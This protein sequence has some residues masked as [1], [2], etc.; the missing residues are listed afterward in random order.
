MLYFHHFCTKVLL[1]CRTD[2]FSI[3][4]TNVHFPIYRQSNTC[5][6][7]VRSSAGVYFFLILLY[8]HFS[9]CDVISTSFRM[10]HTRAA[11]ATLLCLCFEAL[12]GSLD[13]KGPWTKFAVVCHR[14]IASAGVW[15]PS[16]RVVDIY[17]AVAIKINRIEQTVFH[18]LVHF[19]HIH[20]RLHTSNECECRILYVIL[21]TLEHSG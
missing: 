5:T 3:V 7:S 15:T 6:L 9:I 2:R 14:S 10:S 13:F 17:D 8:A 18:F 11:T 4:S 1:T 20:H 19:Q 21:E 16:G 12:T